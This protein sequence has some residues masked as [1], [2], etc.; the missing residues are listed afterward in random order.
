MKRN[1]GM[2]FQDYAIWPH[3]TVAENVDFALRHAR[4]GSLRGD[5]ARKR[6]AEVLDVVGLG[7]MADRGATQLS[8]GQQQRVAL[9]R[10]VV[11]EPDVLLFD[12]PLSNLDARLRA[13]MR[14][15]LRRIAKDL[16]ITSI[17]VTHDQVEALV[18]ANHIAVMKDGEVVQVGTPQDIYR[19]PQDVFVASFIGEANLIK[20]TVLE[21]VAVPDDPGQPMVAVDTEVGRLQAVPS[22]DVQPGETVTVVMRPENLHLG[23][24]HPGGPGVTTNLVSG[25]VETASFAGAHTELVVLCSGTRLHAQV[26]SFEPVDV[27]SRRA[28][29]L[30]CPLDDR[31][32]RRR[33]A[34]FAG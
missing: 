9:A 14:I 1:I 29:R 16:G 31:D 22:Q 23:V 13:M 12:E 11:A 20:G 2:V 33:G 25:T 10:A 32:P 24:H 7:A 21:N 6:V 18:M 30:R 17:Y 27:G 34:P 8:G 4:T 5:A 26:H 3:M 19:H 28:A 15:E